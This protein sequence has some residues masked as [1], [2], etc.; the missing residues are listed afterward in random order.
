MIRRAT[1][2]VIAAFV[3]TALLATT[4]AANETVMVCDV[5]GDQVT[6]QASGL[7]GIGTTEK[8]P[9]NPENA[10]PNTG[11]M[12]IWTGAYNTI[13]QGTAVHWSVSAP[14]GMTITSVYL[15]DMYSQG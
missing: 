7:Y 1:G 14:P 11:G 3:V 12:A 5:Y 8:C 2:S 9:G 6:P 10:P 13:P 15:P 4:A